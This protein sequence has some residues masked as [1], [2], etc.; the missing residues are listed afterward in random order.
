MSIPSTS[1][2]RYSRKGRLIWG[3][4]LVLVMIGL[5]APARRTFVLI[6]PPQGT[7]RLAA[8]AALDPGFAEHKALTLAHILP[9][10]LFL[11]LVPLQ[12][13]RRIRERHIGWHRWSGRLWVV[14]GIAVGT[15]ALAMSYTM[16]I[17]GESETAATTLFALL[18]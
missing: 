9:A 18:F 5:L 15:S 7:P 11:A 13:V 16:S 12:F 4:T 3:L 17:G 1:G 8:A 2:V 10:S 14:L 6:A